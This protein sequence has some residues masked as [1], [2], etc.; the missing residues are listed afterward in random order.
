MRES[1]LKLL[2]GEPAGEIVWTADLNY[3]IAG[4]KQS[5]TAAPAWDAEIGYLELHRDLGIMPYYYYDQFWVAEPTYD[6]RIEV[7]CAAEGTRTIRRWRTPVGELRQE[8]VYMPESCSTCCTRYPVQTEQDLH[9][10]RYLIE[11]RRLQPAALNT[12]PERLEL[13]QRYDGVPCLGLPR[14]P[15]AAFMYEWAGQEHA[16]FFLTDHQN[17]LREIFH[18]MEEQEQ[19]ILQAVCHLAPPVVHFPDNLASDIMTGFYDDFLLPIHTRRLERLHAAGVA[20]AVHL[21]GSVRGLLP[22][23]VQAGFDAVEALTPKP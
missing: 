5:G 9:V 8:E 21:D 22:K 1:F 6:P 23:L 18:T 16:I 2:R 10:L 4:Q 15:L 13:W 17:L 11:H 20:C 19:P 3:W 7:V 12:Y 14:S